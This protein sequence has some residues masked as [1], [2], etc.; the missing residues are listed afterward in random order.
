M[1]AVADANPQDELK[2]AAKD[3]AAEMLKLE[4]EQ[5]VMGEGAPEDRHER[6][7]F[8]RAYGTHIFRAEYRVGPAAG[9]PGQCR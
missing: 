7:E 9:V 5:N 6:C 3:D 2:T 1:E 8:H 4:L